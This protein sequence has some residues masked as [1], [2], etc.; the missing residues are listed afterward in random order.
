MESRKQEL[1][2][3]LQEI[4]HKEVQAEIDKSSEMAGSADNIIK[5]EEAKAR[6]HKEKKDATVHT[7][8]MGGDFL[9][10]FLMAAFI[11]IAFLHIVY[12]G[13]VEA[14]DG[15]K[16]LIGESS[17][18]GNF[19]LLSVIGPLFGMVLSYYFGKSKASANGE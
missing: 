8:V 9:I 5:I 17:G 13:N 7:W 19:Q 14:M 15:G 3:E 16:I 11:S 6:I 1:L 12:T 4:K 18:N 10:K 2:N